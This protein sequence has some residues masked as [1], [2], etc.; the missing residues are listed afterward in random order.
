MAFAAF[1]WFMF[2]PENWETLFWPISL[3][4]VWVADNIPSIAKMTAVSPIPGA[5]RGVLASMAVL[6]PIAGIVLLF[7]DCIDIRIWEF[8]EKKRSA[9]KIVIVPFV[10]ILCLGG[11][12]GFLFWF[13]FVEVKLSFTPTRGQMFLTAMLTD[14]FALAGGTL[15]FWYFFASVVHII[16]IRLLN[17]V[18]FFFEFV[19]I[20]DQND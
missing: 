7:N 1:A 2:I 8:A 19:D 20:G 15:L 18:N 6:T 13:P 11:L 4:L 10:G 16:P 12:C 17:I 9:F 14:R 3:P 5:V